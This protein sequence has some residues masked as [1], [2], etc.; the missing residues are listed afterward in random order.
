MFPLLFAAVVGRATHA[1]L[2][3]RLEKGERIEIL[4]TLAASTSLTSTVTSQL[5]LRQVSFLSL[6]LLVV[7]A[8]SPIGGQASIRQ[9]SVDTAIITTPSE[10]QYAVP[11][12]ELSQI[13]GNGLEWVVDSVYNGAL[14]ASSRTRKS[15]VDAWGNV[16]IPMIERYENDGASDSDRWYDSGMDD[17]DLAK[18]ASL[19]GVPMAGVQS[20]ATTIDYEM[21]LQTSYIQLNCTS[22][23]STGK[24]GY[25]QLPSD[26]V[27]S[28]GY[29]GLIWWSKDQMKARF[30]QR[31]EML[32]PLNFTYMSESYISNPRVLACMMT[33]SYVEVGV[34]C[35]VNS[36]CR[37][38]KLRRSQL[39][40]LPAA[41][42]QMDVNSD[43]DDAD[44]KFQV[45]KIFVEAFAANLGVQKISSA[46]AK[47]ILDRYLKDPSLPIEWTTTTLNT[48]WPSNADFSH[49]FAQLL[50]TYMDSINNLFTISNGVTNK[51]SYLQEQNQTFVPTQLASKSSRD[52]FWAT[53]NFTGPFAKSRMWSSSGLAHTHI[54]VIT[55][56]KPWS[57]TLATVSL[58]LILF[59]L[60]PPLIRHFLTKG[61][62][63]AMNFSSLATRHNAHVP[64]PSTGSFL[65]AAE[66]FRLLKDLRLRLGDG[67]GKGEAGSLVIGAL[68]GGR[69]IG[70]LGRGRVYE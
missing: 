70:R 51:T 60:I 49:R 17:D 18:Y 54:E 62:D 53:Y 2:L 28:T 11:I 65:E 14:A 30:D 35:T 67:E 7:W 12:W 66:R 31:P 58:A 43:R 63:V 22:T 42:T 5:H 19:V 4:D 36:T 34:L 3:W 27:N 26:A 33:T 39:P 20:G 10:F 13:A 55:A 23:N 57:I 64:I 1:I 24:M 61:P 9:M 68:G 59:S 45:W 38:T 21:H 50:N 37:A 41:F 8:L 47:N 6:V 25:G 69:E 56:H 52:G 32:T 15:P 40:Q 46:G 16:K 29:G 44:N 48:S